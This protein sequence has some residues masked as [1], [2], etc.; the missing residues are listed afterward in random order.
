MNGGPG[1]SIMSTIILLLPLIAIVFRIRQ[2]HNSFLA[3]ITMILL[4]G[5]TSLS[6]SGIFSFSP[7]TV[8]FINT[9]SA[10]V[11]PLLTLLFL[12]Y[13]AQNE[14][15]RKALTLTVIIL[16]VTGVLILSK[17]DIQDTAEPAV[18][19]LGILV[20]S[21][22]SIFFFLQQIKLSV[23]QRNA[24]GK[25]FMISAIVFVNCCYALIFLAYYF[26]GTDNHQDLFTIYEIGIVIFS[27][28]LL[29]GILLNKQV[30]AQTAP[31]PV[32]KESGVKEWEGFKTHY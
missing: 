32:K 16:L 19:G 22:F 10:L 17:K 15:V 27:I 25:A 14:Q 21:A 6:S 5:F 30:H 13:F 8:Q 23:H 1:F 4:I 18:L 2:W 3:L 11:Q 12:V 31:G 26:F 29:A 24:M 7:A 28:L 9:I 20:V